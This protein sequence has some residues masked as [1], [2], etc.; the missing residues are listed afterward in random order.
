MTLGDLYVLRLPYT[1]GAPGKPRP[2]L[3]LF[4]AGIDVVVCRIT[5]KPRRPPVDVTLAGYA[6]SGLVVPSVARLDRLYTVEKM[7]LSRKLGSLTPADLA[8][9][10]S[11]WNTQMRL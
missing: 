7:Q 4:D 5:S 11:V 10:R 3:V 8:A 2:T 6:A 1:S 9:G